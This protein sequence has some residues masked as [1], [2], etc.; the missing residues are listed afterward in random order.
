MIHFEIL[1]HVGR[2]S[3]WVQSPELEFLTSSAGVLLHQ[4]AVSGR[5][6]PVGDYL[7]PSSERLAKTNSP[8]HSGHCREIM[9]PPT[10]LND[11]TCIE[12]RP[13]QSP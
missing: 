12:P 9:A 5:Q 4:P 6:L 13:L 11:L 3:F 7:T 2:L 10:Y 8:L 1:R